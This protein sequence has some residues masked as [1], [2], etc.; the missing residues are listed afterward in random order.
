MIRL[1]SFVVPILVMLATAA[2]VRY[3]QFVAEGTWEE[4]MTVIA[5]NAATNLSLD[6][7][8]AMKEVE[9]L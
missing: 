8:K 1:L 4:A 7:D 5:S 9:W 6:I 2:G 3:S